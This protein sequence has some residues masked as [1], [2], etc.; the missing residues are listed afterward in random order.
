MAVYY[1]DNGSISS[2]A[3]DEIYEKYMRYDPNG[4]DR[5]W[6][7]VTLE[8]ANAII[9]AAIP[10]E[11]RIFNMEATAASMVENECKKTDYFYGFGF[12]KGDKSLRRFSEHADAVMLTAWEK[13]VWAQVE[14]WVSEIQAGTTE[15]TVFTTAY[16]AENLPTIA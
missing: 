8:Q 5:G 2:F 6:V 10:L 3:S 7:K 9:E 4:N 15:P 13:T 12:S 16:V 14:A 1:N 11:Q